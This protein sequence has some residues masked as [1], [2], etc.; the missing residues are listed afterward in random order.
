MT[1]V[2]TISQGEEQKISGNIMFEQAT[3]G[4]TYMIALFTMGEN[5]THKENVLFIQSQH[6]RSVVGRR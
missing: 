2:V 5:P 6:F 3:P 1:P 4:T